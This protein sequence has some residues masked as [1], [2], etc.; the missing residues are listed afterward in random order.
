MAAV[1]AMK[2]V[3]TGGDTDAAPKIWAAKAE[4][5]KAVDTFVS[6]AKT[7]AGAIKDEASFKANYQ[8]VVE[9]CGGCHKDTDGFAPPLR[10][11]FKKLKQ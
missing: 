5:T 4:F 7:A 8:K 9:S 11:S 10:E 2:H 6:I 3:S 1:L